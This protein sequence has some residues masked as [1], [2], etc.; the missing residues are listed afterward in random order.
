[1]TKVHRHLSAAD[2][3]QN[4]HGCWGSEPAAIGRQTHKWGTQSTSHTASLLAS[5]TQNVTHMTWVGVGWVTGSHMDTAS[6]WPATGH[7][8]HRCFFPWDLL[9]AGWSPPTASSRR[10]GPGWTRGGGPHSTRTCPQALTF[11]R[12]WRHH[13]WQLPSY[14]DTYHLRPLVLP[15]MLFNGQQRLQGKQPPAAVS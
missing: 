13:G 5:S 15:S 9:T 4:A 14:T 12:E 8:R 3:L 7:S 11:Q 2:Y 10:K 1:M 6:T